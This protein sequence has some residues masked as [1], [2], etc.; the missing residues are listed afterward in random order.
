MPGSWID[1]E[2]WRAARADL[3]LY[4]DAAIYRFWREQRGQGN[5]L[6]VPVTPE[7]QTGVGIQQAF[8][9]G[10]VINWSAEGGASLAHD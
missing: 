4:P 1:H 8:S 2:L 3:V 7:I 5:Y 6:G 10:A 9:S